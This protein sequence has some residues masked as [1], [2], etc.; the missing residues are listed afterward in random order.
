MKRLGLAF[1]LL[2]LTAALPAHAGEANPSCCAC[3]IPDHDTAVPALFCISANERETIV[4]SQRCEEDFGG[5]F[6]CVK[7]VDEAFALSPECIEDLRAENIIC[8]D[9]A[10]VPA[11]GIP[12]L[13]IVA[14]V[15]SLLGA[16]TLRRRSRS[17]ASSKAAV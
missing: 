10:P 9:L 7:R 3:I 1:G 14:G 13:V 15:L 11:L 17:G 4:A 6:L 2:A 16:M 5:A 12:A 8:P